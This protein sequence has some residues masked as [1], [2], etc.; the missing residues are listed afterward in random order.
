MPLLEFMIVCL[1][2]HVW[3]HPIDGRHATCASLTDLYLLQLARVANYPYPALS[4]AQIAGGN[5]TYAIQG[6]DAGPVILYFHGW[7]DLTYR[8]ALP[9]EYPL[10]D[11]GYQLLVV[12]RPGYAGTALQG[13]VDGETSMAERRGFCVYGSR[14]HHIPL[15]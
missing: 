2:A 8:V 6:P 11:A 5:V 1:G 14:A 9:L 7:G 15:W 10:I 12:H 3:C 4:T 13:I